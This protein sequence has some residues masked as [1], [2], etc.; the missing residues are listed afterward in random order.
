MTYCFDHCLALLLYYCEPLVNLT[1]NKFTNQSQRI[2]A[3]FIHFLGL[4]RTRCMCAVSVMYLW[5][6]MTNV[7]R[8]V[9]CHDAASA[10]VLCHSYDGV[11]TALVRRTHCVQISCTHCT[12]VIL[13]PGPIVCRYQVFCLTYL[14]LLIKFCWFH[15]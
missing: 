13:S 12:A 15:P 1:K 10:I 8:T 14:G 9:R 11:S 6:C 2:M 7:R 4:R 5:V 3:N